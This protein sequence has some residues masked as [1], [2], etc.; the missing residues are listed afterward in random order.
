M[1]LRAALCMLLLAGC[2]LAMPSYAAPAAPSAG[3]IKNI[4]G[5]WKTNWADL[6]L[7]Q[8]G[9]AV[10]GS[11]AYKGG[12]MQGTVIG[13]R[14]NYAWTQ[15]DGKYGKGYFLIAEDGNSLSGRYGYNDDDAGG[16]E[17]TGTRVLPAAP[18]AGAAAPELHR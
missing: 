13:N 16:G 8:T 10:I 18:P 9:A 14:F 4:S 17:W 6:T 15:A 7:T 5:T 1:L 3:G 2:A 12:Q 11:Y